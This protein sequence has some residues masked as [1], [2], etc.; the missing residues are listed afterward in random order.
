M[1][2]A[3]YTELASIIA[4]KMPE[5]RWVDLWHEQVSFLSSEL[6]FPTPAVF[7][8][9]RTLSCEDLS[10]KSQELNLQVDFRLF[11]ETFSDTYI[12]SANLDSALE[13][14]QS[15]TNLHKAFHA[16]DG[17]N[18]SE[19]RRVYVGGEDSGGAGN[20]C[21]VSFQCIA[22]DESAMEDVNTVIVQDVVVH[23]APA[24]P[25]STSQPYGLFQLPD[26]VD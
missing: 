15:K 24:P 19:M 4:A 12:G 22:L 1:D 17:V 23:K 11:H 9:W 21:R 6:P 25:D 18:F 13:F 26:L 8:D 16:T 7:I 14:L 5:I 2:K 20:M 10:L 3:L